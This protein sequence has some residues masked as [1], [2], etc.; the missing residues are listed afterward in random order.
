MGFTAF[1]TTWYTDPQELDSN[2]DGIGD[3]QEWTLRASGGIPADS[4]NNQVPDLF[5]DDNDGDGVPD[6]VD[7]SPY[8]GDPTVFNK[9]NPFSLVLNELNPGKLTYVEFQ[10]RPTNPD[11]IWYAYNVLDWPE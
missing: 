2:G 8:T 1:G 4:D 9:D 11:H 3:G 5:D 6:D 7:L 10:L